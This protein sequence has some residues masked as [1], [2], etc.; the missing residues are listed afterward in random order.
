MWLGLLSAVLLAVLAI[1]RLPDVDASTFMVRDTPVSR[2]IPPPPTQLVENVFEVSEG[3]P[4]DDRL[5][6]LEEGVGFRPAELAPGV[7]VDE[8]G[9]LRGTPLR[10]GSYTDP[11][12]MCRGR[13]CVQD[14]VTLVVHRNVSWQPGEL[15]FPGRVGRPVEGRIPIIG[16]PGSVL[17]TFT[18]TDT[19]ALPPGVVIGPDGYVS[20]V[21]ERRGVYEVP[22]R[23]CLAGNCAGVVVTLIIV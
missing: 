19:D 10:P 7:R 22:V 5:I 17:A 15:T 1:P 20:G 4:V 9:H 18:V 16:G 11:V 13:F 8:F 12:S 3:I 6:P 21:P 23:I 2:G 14:Q